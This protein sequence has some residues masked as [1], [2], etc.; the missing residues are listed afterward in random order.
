[1]GRSDAEDPERGRRR[2]GDVTATPA[3]TH[4]TWRSVS[5]TYRRVLYCNWA[6]AA[7]GKGGS[8]GI[9]SYKH[10]KR[11]MDRGARLPVAAAVRCR[12]RY[13]TDGGVIGSREY[14]QNIFESF[15]AQFGST[16]RSGPRGMK[17]SSPKEKDGLTVLRDLRTEVFG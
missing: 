6:S 8:G 5:T 17:R 3:G 1:M 4:A 9:I 10:W 14:V 7:P 2:G 12:V 16:R 15:R 11:E 13:F